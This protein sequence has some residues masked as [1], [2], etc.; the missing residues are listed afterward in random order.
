[1][2]KIQYGPASPDN[3]KCPG[4][5]GHCYLDMDGLLANLFD[6]LSQQLH[7]KT[8]GRTTQQ[9][10]EKTHELWTDKGLFRRHM[11]DLEE[12]F[13]QLPPYPTNTVLFNIICEKFGGFH[14][15]SRPARIDPEASIRGK[16]RWIAQHIK[17]THGNYLYGVHF[18]TT[19]EIFAVTDETPN[20]LIDDYTPYVEA[21]RS[22]GGLAIRVRSDKFLTTDSFR[23][24]LLAELEKLD[25]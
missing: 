25:I 11:G 14:I 21:W 6:T 17:P 23:Q 3:P 20:L 15:C 16:L 22:A 9:E 7:R 5:P 10:R 19:K 18:P 8:Y 2:R 12:L 4:R 1:M 24:Y 13:A